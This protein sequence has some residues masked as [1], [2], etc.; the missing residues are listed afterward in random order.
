M[1]KILNII[2]TLLTAASFSLAAK[3][4]SLAEAKALYEKGAYEDAKPT[5]KQLVKTQP[6]NGNYC[7]WYGVCCLE[8]G[9]PSE[10]LKYLQTAVKRRIPSGQY[11]LA[12]CYD[13]LYRYEEAISE[14][15]SYIADLK[16]RRRPTDDPEALLETYR[17]HLRMLKG[18]EQVEV[19]DS[20][21][22]DKAS[23]LEHY[24]LSEE[25]GKL[26]SYSSYF[27]NQDKEGGLVYETGIGNKIYFSERQEDGRLSIL[28]ATKL[29]NSWSSP[30]LLP[31]NINGQQ[32]ADY[33]FILADGFTIYYA[34]DGQGS[35]G[36][37]DIFVTRY[38]TANDTYLTP[39][40]IGMPF[41][42]PYNDYLYA[43]DEYNNI[44]WFASD[45]FQP[46]GKVCIYL[47]IPNDTKQV[48]DYENT[49]TKQL[50]QLA[51]LHDIHLTWNNPEHIDSAHQRLKL[52][53]SERSTPATDKAEFRFVINDQHV[54][55][56]LSD[57]RSAEAKQLFHA[58]RQ[59]ETA[60]YQQEKKLESMRELYAT[61]NTQEKQRLREAILDQ[62]KRI[63]DLRILVKQKANE[64][65]ATEVK[66]L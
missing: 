1:K 46:E 32:N 62:E 16:R 9:E 40:N 60:Y 3:A 33:P 50:I 11:Q 59:V 49:D 15:E 31:D 56:K 22:V 2:L 44:G 45:R 29:M 25:S 28:T 63:T 64:V 38:N 58:Y 54:Y 7:L 6:T 66:S 52:V 21:V 5:F 37:Y 34:A 36:G 61:A 18:V 65:R 41:N 53:I 51:Q 27:D 30:T 12:R 55:N 43:I 20:I 17:T 47:F 19:I 42:S 48:Y 4:Q 35:M 39:E 8:T 13:Y 57:F 10:G 23:L 24:R 14:M 26:C